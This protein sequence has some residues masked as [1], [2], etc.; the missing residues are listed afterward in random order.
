M[1]AAAIQALL[2]FIEINFGWDVPANTD[3]QMRSLSSAGAFSPRFWNEEINFFR[4][5][6][7]KFLS[8]LIYYRK[9]FDIESSLPVGLS[10]DINAYYLHVLDTIKNYI[11][12][13]KEFFIIWNSAKALSLCLIFH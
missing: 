5:I 6:K 10:S 8:K 1:A 4:N 12:S 9:I 2:F 13:N 7:P 3:C 11:E